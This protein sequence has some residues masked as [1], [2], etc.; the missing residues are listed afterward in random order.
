MRPAAACA[1]LGPARTTGPARDGRGPRGVGAGGPAGALDPATGVATTGLPHPLPQVRPPAA[2]PAR[3]F[4]PTVRPGPPGPRAGRQL[5]GGADPDA[6][7]IRC[8]PSGT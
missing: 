6:S 4:P 1:P 8:R 7:A 2:G 5:L 3:P